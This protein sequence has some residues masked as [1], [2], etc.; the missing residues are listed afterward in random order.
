MSKKILYKG[1]LSDG[2]ATKGLTCPIRF[3]T[4]PSVPTIL[5]FYLFAHLIAFAEEYARFVNTRFDE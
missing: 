1:S 3:I 2:Q 5:N 4:I